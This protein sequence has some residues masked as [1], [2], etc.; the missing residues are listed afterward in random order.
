MIVCVAI[1]LFGGVG[2]AKVTDLIIIRIPDATA[3]QNSRRL[4]VYQMVAPPRAVVIGAGAVGLAAGPLR[5]P[6]ARYL[7]AAT[8]AL[9]PRA[10]ASVACSCVDMCTS[11]VSKFV[12]TCCMNMLHQHV[13]A[14]CC[15]GGAVPRAVL[16]GVVIDH[17]HRYPH[18]G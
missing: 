13:D 1:M 4:P 11:D 7:A 14:T 8:T 2:P 17:C 10:R 18:S 15:R 9:Q 16:K 5:A 12:W 6:C 3:G